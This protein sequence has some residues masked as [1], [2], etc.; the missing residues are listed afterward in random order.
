MLPQRIISGTILNSKV[1]AGET[2]VNHLAS[3]LSASVGYHAPL[4]IA[5]PVIAVV[6]IAKVVFSLRKG[7]PGIAGEVTVRC[8]KGHVFTTIWSPLGSLTS[9][10]LG[11]V[12]FQRCPVGPHWSLV[13]PVDDADLTDGD[14]DMLDHGR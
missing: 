5:L 3:P 14:R 8:G 12:R 1:N 10:R 11:P 6:I 7:R 2:P 4:E 13:R 9:V